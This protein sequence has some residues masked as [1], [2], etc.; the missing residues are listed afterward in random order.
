MTENHTDGI[1]IQ[2]GKM[3]ALYKVYYQRMEM[4]LLALLAKYA[5]HRKENS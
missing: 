5:K 4:F 1:V 3:M 2:N